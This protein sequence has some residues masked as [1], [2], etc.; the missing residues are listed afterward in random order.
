MQ[1]RLC[2]ADMSFGNMFDY[3]N[4]VVLVTM[5]WFNQG[6]NQCWHVRVGVFKIIVMCS[7]DFNFILLVY[8]L[9]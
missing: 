9:G 8:G 2:D 3:L 4:N 7:L 1:I 6:G 5:L